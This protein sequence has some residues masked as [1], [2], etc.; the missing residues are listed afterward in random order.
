[1]MRSPDLA[2]CLESPYLW[3][4]ESAATLVTKDLES[5]DKYLASVKSQKDAVDQIVTA[6]QAMYQATM[7]LL[8]A[9][10]YK[11]SGFRAI[12]TVLNDYF[13]QKGLLDK[14]HVEHLLR[15][16]RLEGTP[17][18]NNEAAV[19]LVAAVKQALGKT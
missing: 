9:I 8:H 7:A 5:A 3:F 14:I 2:A 15:G 11:A 1:M 16:Q 10:Q 13:V 4:D 19:A 18:E 6:Y 17:E 12:V